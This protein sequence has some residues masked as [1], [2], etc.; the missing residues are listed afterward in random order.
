MAP[1]LDLR[2]RE[3]AA[4]KILAVFACAEIRVEI[5][6]NEAEC[7]RHVRIGL[8]QLADHD[9][10]AGR[11]G[12]PI[13]FDLRH[14]VP[15]VAVDMAEEEATSDH[16]RRVRYGMNRMIKSPF[17]EEEGIHDPSLDVQNRVEMKIKSCRGVAT[18]LADCDDGT[19]PVAEPIVND[20][21]EQ[22]VSILASW[23]DENMRRQNRIGRHFVTHH[24]LVLD[25]DV[26]R[27]SALDKAGGYP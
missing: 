9:F 13:S 5:S 10:G 27:G 2:K 18:S 20:V 14:A 21:G 17:E 12:S 23:L 1:D 7:H 6:K 24:L 25:Q 8:E 3:S 19:L 15:A 26:G 11:V 16:C 22:N 4:H